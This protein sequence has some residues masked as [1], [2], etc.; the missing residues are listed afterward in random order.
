[1]KGIEKETGVKFIMCFIKNVQ[2]S[3]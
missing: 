1:M 2:E 3:K